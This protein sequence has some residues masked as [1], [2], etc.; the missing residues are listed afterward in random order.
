M[1]RQLVLE[2]RKDALR[3]LLKEGREI[4]GHEELSTRELPNE[5]LK[6]KLQSYKKN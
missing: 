6:A 3:I 5:L 4:R 1:K 2:F